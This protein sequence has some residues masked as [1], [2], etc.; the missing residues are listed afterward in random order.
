MAWRAWLLGLEVG[1]LLVFVLNQGRVLALFYV[2]RTD[3]TLFDVLHSVIAPLLLILAAS[4]FFL[5]WLNRYGS[6][7]AAHPSA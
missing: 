1:C 5:V 7:I 2:F 6:R 4:A 3:R